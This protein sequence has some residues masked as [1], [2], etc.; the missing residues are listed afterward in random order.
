MNEPDNE[1]LT[2]ETKP[3]VPKFW[4]TMYHGTHSSRPEWTGD[5]VKQLDDNT[6]VVKGMGLSVKDEEGKEQDRRFQRNIEA[7]GG[8][9]ASGYDTTKDYSQKDPRNPNPGGYSIEIRILFPAFHD[10]SDL[11]KSAMP[12]YQD[13]YGEAQTQ[14]ILDLSNRV[15]WRNIQGGRHPVIPSGVKLKKLL[16]ETTKDG[17]RI[18]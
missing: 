1:S 9:V 10:R 15:H 8:V 4:T 14:K 13:K 5:K 2:T 7:Q 11:K 12:Y 17:T 16:D 18:I 3:Q 6:F